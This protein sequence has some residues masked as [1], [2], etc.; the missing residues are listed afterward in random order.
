MTL[1]KNK[2]G[3]GQQRAGR[4]EAG[5]REASEALWEPGARRG[6]PGRGRE[7]GRPVRPCGSREPGG[8]SQAGGACGPTTITCPGIFWKSE[9]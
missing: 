2:A 8:G 1:L 7:A 4:V 5:S 6:E 3:G 9:I